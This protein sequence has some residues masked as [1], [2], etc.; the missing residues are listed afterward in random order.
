MELSTEEIMGTVMKELVGMVVLEL[1]PM[2]TLDPEMDIGKGSVVRGYIH[3]EETDCD[4]PQSTGN[5]SSWPSRGAS[6]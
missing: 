2:P 4:V 6:P 3:P 5:P 1:G